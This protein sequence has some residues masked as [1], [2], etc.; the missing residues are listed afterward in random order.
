VGAPLGKGERCRIDYWSRR[1][2]RLF[3]PGFG[4]SM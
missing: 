4:R 1:C 2:E 3:A